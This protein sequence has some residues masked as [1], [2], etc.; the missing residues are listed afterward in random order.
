MQALEAQI[1]ANDPP[2]GKVSRTAMV[3]P[4]SRSIGREWMGTTAFIGRDLDL[5][6]LAAAVVA[7]PIVTIVGPGGVGK[8]RLAMRVAGLVADGFSDGVTVVELASQ[9][10]PGGTVQVIARALDIQPHKFDTIESTVREHLRS[11]SVLLLL[12]NCEHLIDAVAPLVDRLQSSCNDLHILATSREP[13]C[14]AGEYVWLL[15]PLDV[16]S[17][18][19]TAT[20]KHQATAVQLFASRAAS[21]TP[22]FVLT[23]DNVDVVAD[24]CRRLDGLPLGLELASARLR[25]MG[26][27]TLIVRLNQGTELEG[28]T[29]RGGDERQRTLRNLAEWSYELLSPGERETFEQLTV[30]VGGFDLAAAESV[31]KVGTVRGS[32]ISH[33]SG[34]VDKSM[35]VL[36]DPNRARYRML[37]PLREFGHRLLCEHELDHDTEDR[38]LNWFIALAEAGASGLDGAD[39]AIWS[40]DIDR[41]FDNFRAAHVIAVERNDAPVGTRSRRSSRGVRNTASAV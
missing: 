31:C 40:D 23:D 8:T 16:P 11:R 35:V 30:F 36:V 28:Q 19:A 2:L 41:E 21:A 24:I 20:E 5:A 4:S 17:S 27:G 15:D 25:T 32:I 6:S 39:E 26:L 18:D 9:R 14:L 13:L 33:L 3:M 29:Q 38:H 37:E 7:E 1:L 34:L 22:G 12:D 10:D